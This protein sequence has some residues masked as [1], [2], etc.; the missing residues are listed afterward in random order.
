MGT[1]KRGR[2]EGEQPGWRKGDAF[3]GFQPPPL[4]PG[5]ILVLQAQPLTREA[6][7]MPSLA[8]EPLFNLSQ[9]LLVLRSFYQ[10][11]S[12]VLPTPL[13]LLEGGN[14]PAELTPS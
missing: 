14:E 2:K 13:L 12:Q 8:F 9:M 4:P 6:L 3:P 1:W 7:K 5:S 11:T 10:A